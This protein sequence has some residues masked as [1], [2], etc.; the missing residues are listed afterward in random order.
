MQGKKFN[1]Q[2]GGQNL[3]F[4]EERDNHRSG[5]PE[6]RASKPVQTAEEDIQNR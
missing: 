6:S 1:K 2:V 4:V 5:D 3:I